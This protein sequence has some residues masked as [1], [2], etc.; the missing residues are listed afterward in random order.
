MPK[1]SWPTMPHHT[2]QTPMTPTS[3]TPHIHTTIICS[4][5]PRLCSPHSPQPHMPTHPR[6]Y[7]T[8]YVVKYTPSQRVGRIS[9][10]M[11]QKKFLSQKHGS[12]IP[13]DRQLLM[14]IYRDIGSS[15][16]PYD[17]S[18]KNISLIVNFISPTWP[19]FETRPRWLISLRS[20][21]I[22][23]SYRKLVFGQPDLVFENRPHQFTKS[24]IEF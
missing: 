23:S 15:R 4:V 1:P 7:L 5:I 11:W 18:W 12:N 2:N 3:M 6:H 9:W 17:Y 16:L 19:S 13:M 24:R 20:R 21:V 22:L 10:N 8:L 14:G